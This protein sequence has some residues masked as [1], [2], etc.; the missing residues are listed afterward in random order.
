MVRQTGLPN[1]MERVVK[2]DKR[3]IGEL[4]ITVL[5]NLERLKKGGKVIKN[6]L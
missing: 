4:S 3:E 1:C 2:D 6:T 5:L